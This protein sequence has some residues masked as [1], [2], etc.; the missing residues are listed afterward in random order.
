MK[1]KVVFEL[2]ELAPAQAGAARTVQESEV[3]GCGAE[4]GR[5]ESDDHV[6]L[7]EGLR[8]HRVSVL[9]ETIGEAVSLK[10]MRRVSA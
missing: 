3:R 8:W 5:R 10:R 7:T 4:G 9:L 6:E 2:E 1:P